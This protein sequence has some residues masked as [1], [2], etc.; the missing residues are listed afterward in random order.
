M[1]H[2][3][4]DVYVHTALQNASLFPGLVFKAKDGRLWAQRWL[5]LAVGRVIDEAICMTSRYNS[6]F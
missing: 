6:P 1:G 5:E 2:Q 4:S 3:L